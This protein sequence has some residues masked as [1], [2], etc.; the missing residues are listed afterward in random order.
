S[1]D[2]VDGPH[3]RQGTDVATGH[4]LVDGLGPV[5][6]QV[7]V[8]TQVAPQVED[9]G[10]DLGGGP[11]GRARDRRAVPPIDAIEPPPLGPLD[12]ALDGGEADLEL[13]GY[14]PERGVGPPGRLHESPAKIGIRVGLLMVLSSKGPEFFTPVYRANDLGVVA[15]K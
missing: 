9:G 3:R 15:Q 2:A 5:E 6:A 12:P 11:P 4:L 13:P 10:L 14:G 8:L 7:A 1:E